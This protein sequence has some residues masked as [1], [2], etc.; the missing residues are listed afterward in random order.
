MICIDV[1]VCKH[2]GLMLCGD[3]LT[4]WMGPGKPRGVG[5]DPVLPCPTPD[6]SITELG[7]NTHEF[8]NTYFSLSSFLYLRVYYY[9]VCRTSWGIIYLVC[10]IHIWCLRYCLR[11]VSDWF[12]TCLGSLVSTAAICAH[13]NLHCCT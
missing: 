8:G 3:D 12:C 2:Q 1:N 10:R 5:L 13:C 4:R 7:T 6:V 9:D 11:N